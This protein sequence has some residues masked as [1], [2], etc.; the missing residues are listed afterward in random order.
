M[1]KK[2]DAKSVLWTIEQIRMPL[3]IILIALKPYSHSL[4]NYF[5]QLGLTIIKFTYNFNSSI[6]YSNKLEYD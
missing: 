3:T 1:R 5:E 2:W 4:E 6:H